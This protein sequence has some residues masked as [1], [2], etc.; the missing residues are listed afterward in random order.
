[1]YNKSERSKLYTDKFQVRSHIN[2]LGR[3]FPTFRNELSALS[4][5]SHL[6]FRT[7][8]SIC[9]M[10]ALYLTLTLPPTHTPKKT[11]AS[12][13]GSSV[14]DRRRKP[15]A[16]GSRKISTSFD[17]SA[18]GGVA[19]RLPGGFDLLDQAA[20]SN[21]PREI[22]PSPPDLRSAWIHCVLYWSTVFHVHFCF[23]RLFI[24]RG[25]FGW[26]VLWLLVVMRL[27]R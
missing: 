6:V 4:K 16:L 3:T 20:D 1:M 19:S 10:R 27:L 14:S 15:W 9:W 7:C 17:G 21:I 25:H 13:V 22:A 12:L 23:I 8:P 2:K 18:Y 24:D 11:L 26:R 5:P